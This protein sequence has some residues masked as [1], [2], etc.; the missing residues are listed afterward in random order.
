M[1]KNQIADLT[2]KIIVVALFAIFLTFFATRVN[3]QDSLVRI[4]PETARYFLEADDELKILQEKDSVQTR[5]INSLTRENY[6]KNQ[7][8]ATYQA[9]ALTYDAEY[10]LLNTELE[11]R[12]EDVKRLERKLR[13]RK[14]AEIVGVVGLT[15]LL[16]L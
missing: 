5:L 14:I 1:K 3:A 7:V 15:V 6:L 9:D 10:D 13:I 12:D 11:A 16:I 4:K 2:W 8:I